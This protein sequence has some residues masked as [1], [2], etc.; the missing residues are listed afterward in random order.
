[1]LTQAL[2]ND[3]HL[4]LLEPRHAEPLFQVVDV[5]RAHLRVWL[6]WL[7]VNT[8]AADTLAFIRR[9]QKQ[10]GEN[11]GFQAVISY[12]GEIAGLVG[13]VRIDWQNRSTALGYWL[14]EAMQGRGIMTRACDAFLRH[15]FEKLNLNRVE[16]RAATE[17]TRSR[18]V[19]ERLGFKLEGVVREAEWLYDH[20]VDHAVYGLLQQDWAVSDSGT[21]A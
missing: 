13:H 14:A 5:N 21:V 15:A 8:S 18:A 3:L 4:E 9:T 7:D 16:I 1:M 20:F 11:N 12:R 6:P 19:P 17:N 10:A 2:A